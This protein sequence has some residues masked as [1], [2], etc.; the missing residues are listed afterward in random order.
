MKPKLWTYIWTEL[1]QLTHNGW[2]LNEITGHLLVHSL[3]GSLVWPHSLLSRLL[4]TTCFA[5]CTHSSAHFLAYFRAQ[6]KHRRLLDAF[7]HLYKRVCPSV[8]PSVRPSVRPSIRWSVGHTQVET[9]Q[10]H[11]F[12]PNLPA[13]RARTHLMPCIRPC[14]LAYQNLSSFFSPLS[15]LTLTTQ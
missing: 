10:N 4:C 11:R 14:F 5:C 13:V 3:V 15:P 7:S 2:K 8:G 6:N 12:W 9:L 1:T